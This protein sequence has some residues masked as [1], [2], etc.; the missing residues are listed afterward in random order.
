MPEPLPIPAP[1][2][3]A[4]V[5]IQGKLIFAALFLLFFGRHW[6]RPVAGDWAAAGAAA[7]AV[8][9]GLFPARAWGRRAAS[10]G[11]LLLSYA[12]L[13]RYGDGPG[14]FEAVLASGLAACFGALALWLGLFRPEAH[15]TGLARL[16]VALSSVT[17]LVG[18]AGLDLLPRLAADARLLADTGGLWR[19]SGLVVLWAAA[20]VVR[21]TSA[22]PGAGPRDRPVSFYR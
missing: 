8:A 15:E 17:A 1:P 10:L 7:A 4:P 12:C 6:L 13:A 16:L 14:G 9:A 11:A 18:A 19:W 21:Q 22:G 5:S 2:V 3:P 20:W